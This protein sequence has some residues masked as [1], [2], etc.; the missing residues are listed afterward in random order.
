MNARRPGAPMPDSLRATLTTT[1][2]HPARA[3][4]CPHCRA[5]PGKPCVL[6]TNGRALPEPH[7]TRVTAWEQSTA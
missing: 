1:V 2:G 3:I 5:L 6:R 4:Q 7:H